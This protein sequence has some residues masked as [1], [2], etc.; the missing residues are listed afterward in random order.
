MPPTFHRA[1]DQNLNAPGPDMKWHVSRVVERR[2]PDNRPLVELDQQ[3]V[4]FHGDPKYRP[5]PTSLEWRVENLR[6][7]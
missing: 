7:E 6:R 2:I 5:S 4:I 1:L 3:D